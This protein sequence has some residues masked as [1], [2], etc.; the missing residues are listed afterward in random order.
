M[1]DLRCALVRQAQLS[2]HRFEVRSSCGM[3]EA[4]EEEV[5]LLFVWDWR[6]HRGERSWF[7]VA[8]KRDGRLEC[9]KGTWTYRCL[10]NFDS[11][12]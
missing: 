12:C 7:E 10:I 3:P 2:R 6:S 9:V 4:G 1:T 8:K 5:P 11:R